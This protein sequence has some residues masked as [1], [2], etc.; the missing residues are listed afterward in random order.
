MCAVQSPT[1]IDSPLN[2]KYPLTKVR[3]GGNIGVCLHNVDWWYDGDWMIFLGQGEVCICIW[4]HHSLLDKVQTPLSLFLTLFLTDIMNSPRDHFSLH[5]IWSSSSVTDRFDRVT[6]RLDKPQIDLIWFLFLLP[7]LHALFD[8]D[9][10]KSLKFIY[11]ILG[12]V[13]L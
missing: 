9:T 5:L 1:G 3:G 11:I 4:R 8:R 13:A 2:Q 7:P 10:M 6:D 12:P